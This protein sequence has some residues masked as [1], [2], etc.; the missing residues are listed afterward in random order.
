MAPLKLARD[1]DNFSVTSLTK[2]IVEFDNCFRLTSYNTT[3]K[4]E[5]F[6]QQQRQITQKLPQ[7]CFLK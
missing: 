7:K 2:A 6:M 4:S 3:K 5:I 1:F